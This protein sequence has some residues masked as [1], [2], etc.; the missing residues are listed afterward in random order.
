MLVK[1]VKLIIIRIKKR[2]VLVQC[3]VQ[4]NT[5]WNE[6]NFLDLVSLNITAKDLYNYTTYYTNCI[7]SNNWN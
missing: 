2:K 4:V 5:N 6:K 7:Q 1:N 3:D